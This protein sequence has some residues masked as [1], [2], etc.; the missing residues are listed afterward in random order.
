MRRA[1]GDSGNG[2]AAISA[3]QVN[4]SG[5]ASVTVSGNYN[6]GG[7]DVSSGSRGGIGA[8]TAGYPTAISISG[9]AVVTA[10]GNG[11]SSDIGG[12]QPT[13][14]TL[15]MTGGTL[16]LNGTGIGTGASCSFKSC[17]VGGSAGGPV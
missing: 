13:Q 15:E 9:N 10:M 17:T 6:G 2:A 8:T 12:P 3:G 5:D 16:N 4:I 14:T 7:F 1:N 11:K